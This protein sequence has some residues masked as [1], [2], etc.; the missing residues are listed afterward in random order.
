MPDQKINKL[1]KLLLVIVIHALL[2]ILLTEKNI[3]AFLSF[4]RAKFSWS[5]ILPKILE[6][7]VVRRLHIGAGL[8]GEQ[9]AE[10]MHARIMKLERDYR[11]I[12]DE[13]P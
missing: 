1:G 2:I 11:G 7:H 6:D 12:K 4:Y 13:L 9:G 5:T 3:Q 8:M 10:S